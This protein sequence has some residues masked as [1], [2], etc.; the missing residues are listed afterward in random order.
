M[1]SNSAADSGLRRAFDVLAAGAALFFLSP[2]LFAIALLVKLTS[3]G[4][5]LYRAGRIGQGGRR[6]RLYKFRSMAADAAQSVIFPGITSAGD[7][8]IT[9]VGRWLRR[10]KIDELPQ[11]INVL[12]GEMSL[13]GPRPEDPRYVALYTL[14][15]RRV[16]A[17]PPGITSPAS[18][19]YR[20]EEQMLTGPDWESTYVN[21][22]MP[23][24]LRIE[25]E[26]LEHRTFLSDLRII[27]QTAAVLLPHQRTPDGG[28][29]EGVAP[30]PST[31]P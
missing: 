30:P 25:L 19:R 22:I 5:A 14:E 10:L 23:D 7:S 24:K 9:R 17:V 27:L 31:H 2:L 8:R 13:V 11:L 4:P 1:S 16:L 28:G 3:P 18:I 29:P 20:S 15:Q 6:F 12:R 21:V 26:Y